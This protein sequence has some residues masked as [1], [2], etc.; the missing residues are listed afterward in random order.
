MPGTMD[1][2]DVLKATMDLNFKGDF[3][4]MSGHGT[5]ETAVKATKLGAWDFVEK[6]LS[7]DKINILLTNLLAFQTE[8]QQKLSILNKLRQSFSLIGPSP[9]TIRL[10][11]TI[12]KICN[13]PGP[14]LL[15]GEMG[16]GKHLASQH[17]HY[18]SNR[19]F[20]PFVDVN[21]AANSSELVN[22][23]LFGYKAGFFTGTTGD[24]IGKLEVCNEGTIL[25]KEI[26][27]LDLEVQDKIA[28]FLKDQVIK[29]LGGGK[30][31]SSQVR[32]LFSTTADLSELVEK[33]S[34]SKALFEELR[35]NELIIPPLRERQD[36]IRELVDHF[37]RLLE[38]EG[39]YSPK[40]F[41]DDAFNKMQEH[42]WPGN[43]RELK[44]FVERVFILIHAEEISA[45]EIQLAGIT[46]SFDEAD[47]MFDYNATLREARSQF[48]KDFIL[49]KLDENDGNI[50]KTAE[51]IGV[52]RSHL[53]RKIKSYG[54]DA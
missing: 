15:R 47:R 39:A 29:P 43:V 38:K 34:F 14:I 17:I 36:D 35:S 6:P 11:E 42:S 44:N 30:E 19:A 27:S 22:A 23:D 51:L 28:A 49:K 37:S 31:S 24:K 25:L 9:A 46:N 8:K 16:A 20:Y 26:E 40:K 4:V 52:E 54:I 13:K 7:I 5:I 50:S 41:S 48:E 33:N 18:F 1:G 45:K 32:L 2:L 21:C 53:H 3:I 12:S 10:K